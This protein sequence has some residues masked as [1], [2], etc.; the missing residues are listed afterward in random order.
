M[1]FIAKWRAE[2][3][4]DVYPAF[5]LIVPDKD[6]DRMVYG[7]KEKAIA[8]IWVK[9]L[10]IN[11]HSEDALALLNWK[12]PTSGT[13]LASGF[14]AAGTKAGDFA[15]RVFDVVSKRA[16]KV[17]PGTMT[18][19]EVNEAL[20]RLAA[21]SGESKYVPIFKHFYQEMCAEEI[22][23]LVRIVLRQMKI[24]ASEKTLFDVW[25]PDAAALFKVTSSLRKVCWDLWD[26]SVQLKTTDRSVRPLECFQPQ[27]AQFQLHDFEAM[28][29]KMKPTGEDGVFWIEEKLDGERMQLHMK[30]DEAIEG[31]KRFAFWSRR[32]KDYTYL[33]GDGFEDPTGS[34]TRHLKDVFHE[35]VESIVLDG[36]MIA[37]DPLEKAMVAFGTL[38]TAALFEGDNPQNTTGHRPLLRV[39]DILYINGKD[40]TPYSLRERRKALERCIAKEIPGRFEIHTCKEGTRAED[41]EMSLRKIVEEAS[42]G[43]VL[44]NPRT[45]YSLSERNDAWLKVKPEYMQEYGENLDCVIIGGY[46]GNGARGGFLSSFLC[47]LRVDENEVRRGANQQK[48]MSFLKVGGGFTSHD[49]KTVRHKTGD[50]WEK[51]N[52]TRPPI[53][54]IELG[55]EGRQYE[56]PDEWIRPEDSLVLS[57]KG[58][59]VT[60]T[61]KFA[62]GF[63]LRFPRLQRIREDRDWKTALSFQDFLNLRDKVEQLKSDKMKVDDSRKKRRS[64]KKRKTIAVLGGEKVQNAYAGPST[65]CF[66]GLNFFIMGGST[67]PQKKSKQELEQ[68]VKANGGTIH[69]T[70][71]KNLDIICI[72][73]TNLVQANAL[74]KRGTRNIIKP[75]WLFECIEQNENEIERSR[76]LLDFEPKHI[77]FALEGF[78]DEVDENVDPH[79]DS[80]ARDVQPDE[81]R[82]IFNDMA[83]PKK[84]VPTSAAYEALESRTGELPSLNGWIL[85]GLAIAF[86]CSSETLDVLD[87]LSLRS[88]QA[89]QTAH[90]AGATV[91]LKLEE[92]ETTHVVVG[93]NDEGELKSRAADVRKEVSA[94]SRV[95]RIVSLDWIES[96]WK[97]KTRI[98]EERFP[99]S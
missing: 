45:V 75:S 69:Q 64:T 48:C 49:Y 93:G 78:Q 99:V 53:E 25:H 79:G 27:L 58:A 20:D 6:R 88:Y 51:W 13:G 10:G 24:G 68:L 31:G 43:L 82:K 70:E 19:D 66:E 91:S 15:G 26:P 7:L 47:G 21:E 14:A 97:E 96:C 94:W 38:K 77:L 74:R 2:V 55:G 44:K 85:H 89:R 60:Q 71:K 3:G 22:M 65:E 72:A 1:R 80:Y 37:W 98:D 63:T 17:D 67:K 46:Y 39:F 87:P 56:A 33:Y 90:F 9:V 59:S 52:K 42:E 73:E 86:L 8:R 36:E 76:L 50:K 23:W 34:L 83:K 11:R 95:P 28:V 57:V 5:R 4:P 92:G 61:D 40:I 81:L 54:W 16:M 62:T 12:D 32:A 29:R 18:V 84:S 30:P 41:I 35:G